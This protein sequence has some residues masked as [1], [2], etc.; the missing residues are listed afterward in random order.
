MYWGITPPR[1]D[2]VI[3]TQP[4]RRFGHAL[5]AVPTSGE[6]VG[7]GWGGFTGS[8]IAESVAV[9][10]LPVVVRDIDD[11]ALGAARARIEE[12]LARAVKRRKVSNAGEVLK[13]IEPTTHLGAM[14]DRE[15]M[16]RPPPRT[17]R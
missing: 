8:G 7:R 10:G 5:A 2:Y 9:T 14:R 4:D 17:R 1:V 13:R 3:T 15:L 6:S 16:V 12:S 11:K